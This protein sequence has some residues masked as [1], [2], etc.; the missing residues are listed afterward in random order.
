MLIFTHIDDPASSESY[1]LGMD[2]NRLLSV[3]IVY[4]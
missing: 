2:T 3:C 1:A 4:V